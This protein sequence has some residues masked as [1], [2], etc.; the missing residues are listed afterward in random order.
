MNQS[1][2]TRSVLSVTLAAALRITSQFI[3]T[4]SVIWI[5]R[6][7]NE[8]QGMKQRKKSLRYPLIKLIMMYCKVTWIIPSTCVVSASPAVLAVPSKG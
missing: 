2:C 6:F 7:K 1:C 5:S 8:M 3:T 4:F